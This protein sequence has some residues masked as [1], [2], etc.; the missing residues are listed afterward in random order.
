[1]CALPEASFSALRAS[2]RLL[3]LPRHSNPRS[4]LKSQNL[5]RAKFARF[6]GR[7]LRTQ[8]SRGRAGAP[9]RGWWPSG[10]AS[11]SEA[12]GPGLGS[13]LARAL[14]CVAASWFRSC[15]EFFRGF[16]MGFCFQPLEI[17]G[18]LKWLLAQP[19]RGSTFPITVHATKVYF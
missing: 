9:P 6:S 3:N 2:R 17:A 1:M 14:F 15:R 19:L 18:L 13:F 7:A 12:G 10:L 11:V 8:L 4:G 16:A 5:Q